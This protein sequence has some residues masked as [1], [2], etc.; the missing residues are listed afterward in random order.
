MKLN[1]IK[2]NELS[3]AQ[4]NEREMCRILGGGTAGCCQC[5]CHYAN[6]GGS[7]S[8]ANDSANNASGYT[9]DPGSQTCSCYTSSNP[10]D[11]CTPNLPIQDN[12]CG[13]DNVF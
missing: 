1:K 13:G 4:L 6:S 12:A 5:G 2:L 9:S 11:I 10:S 7:S 3:N 8:S